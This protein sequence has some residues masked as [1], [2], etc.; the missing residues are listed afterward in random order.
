MTFQF[1]N[2]IFSLFPE[3]YKDNDS[4]KDINGEGLL[5]R[6]TQIFGE[7]IDE[8]IIVFAEEFTKNVDMFE[9]DAK[10]LNHIAYA[11]GNPPDVLSDE[12]KYRKLLSYIVSV[13]KI[14]GTKRSYELL[15]NILG[16]N[17]S[18]IEHLPCEGYYYDMGYTYDEEGV[19][20]DKF[21]CPCSQYEIAFSSQDDD[22]ETATINPISQTILDNLYK[23]IFFIEPI[24]A[25]LLSLTYEV[26]FCET[27][28][29]C[30]PDDL[31][32]EVRTYAAYDTGL[33][34]DTGVDYDSYTV[35]S[36]GNTSFDGCAQP[37]VPS[38]LLQE[39]GDNLLQENN[40]NI[41]L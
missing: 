33:D 5:E 22:C 41:E 27:T 6:Y 21:C 16:Y 36:T 34:Y 24:N 17:V 11:L 10:F 2:Y 13:Y 20:Y 18:V 26:N 15:F 30:L 8:K 19:I 39:N 37:P 29:L 35:D 23:I 28:N 7:E 14:K 38:F 25:K 31:D 4:Y 40:D 32:W 3:F 1:A 9:C 12:D